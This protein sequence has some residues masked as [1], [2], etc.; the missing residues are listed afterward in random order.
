MRKCIAAL[1]KLGQISQVH[2]GRWMF[3]ALL[4]PK[5]H[6]EHVRHIEDFVW[7]F[8]VNYIPLNAVTRVTAYPIPR[9]DSAVR[10]SFNGF[11][12]LWFMDAIHGHH[13]IRV[14][15]HTREKLA[16]AGPDAIKWTY[17]VMPFGPVNGPSIFIGFMHDMQSRWNEVAAAE[18]IDTTADV[19]DRLIVDDILS[20]ARSWVLAITYLEC[21]LRV[22]RAQNLSLSLNKCHFFPKRAEYV[23]I[24]I[25]IDGNRPA[26]SKHQ[27]LQA[28][29]TPEIVRDVASFV[30]FAIFY[31]LFI[32]L[33]EVRIARLREIMKFEY[34][35][36]VGRHWDNRAKPEWDDIRHAILSDP[37]LHRFD[38][39]LRV[40]LLSDFCKDGFGYTACQPGAD[41]ASRAA[42]KREDACG[43]CEFL[44]TEPLSLHPIAFGCRRTR[45][46]EVRFHSY[47]GE[48]FAG[49]W[50]INKCRL[51][52]W[53]RTFTWLTDCYALRFILSYDG[54][55]PTILRLQMRLMCWDMTIEHRPGTK[56]PA[57][58]IYLVLALTFALTLSFKNTLRKL[59]LLR[60][61]IPLSVA[62]Q[63]SRKICRVTESHVPYPLQHL[64]RPLKL[65]STTLGLLPW[66]PPFSKK[67][68]LATAIIWLTSQLSS[69]ILIQILINLEFVR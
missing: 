44:K 5:P 7:R 2:G 52:C 11:T 13:Q 12:W 68:R 21:Q 48:G 53:G 27:L 3:K 1:Q 50:A 18:G 37:C 42:M 23:G 36:S 67:I 46:N 24:D 22:C 29:P 63:C 32:P 30:G 34:T 57:L 31:S 55:N 10:I 35:E 14:D 19:G 20:Y 16:F 51:Y 45:D 28:W 49:D 38:K 17:N 39:D 8:C 54:N 61:R 58:I 6:Q 43:N 33:F 59:H 15:E 41:D 25:D 9:C 60:P 62:Y 69:E 40:Y 56:C 65:F 64:Q 47:L 4:A 66:Q 26:Q